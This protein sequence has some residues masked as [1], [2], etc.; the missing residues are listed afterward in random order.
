MIVIIIHLEN[1]KW[2]IGKVKGFV[3]NFETE[4]FNE[5]STLKLR[6]PW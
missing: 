4:S 3:L 5:S 2:T 6:S 1:W